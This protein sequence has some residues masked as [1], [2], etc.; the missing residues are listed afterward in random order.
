MAFN[1]ASI[2]KNAV[3]PPII[4]IHGEP[5]VGKTTFGACAPNPIFLQTEDGLGDLNVVAF[6][7]ITELNQVHEALDSLSN[8]Q[9]E[10]QTLVLDSVD[11]M[12]PLIW[13]GVAK[14]N[15]VDH[16]ERLGYGKGYV[17]AL[18]Y[19]RKVLDKIKE[20][21]DQKNMAI[22]MIAHSEKRKVEDPTMP[23]YDSWDLKLHKRAAAMVEEFADIILFACTQA[24]TVTED[25][26]FNQS[27]TRVTTTGNRIMHT[28][29]QPAFLAKNRFSLPTPLP[30]SWESLATALYGQKTAA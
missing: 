2:R 10:F 29:G 22:V 7:F 8:E 21:R 12:E 17:E 16:I 3:K 27:R 28:V 9:H 23:A 13:A 19:W 15:K 26:G 30:L 11:W 18:N 6:P 24:N 5:G 4:V 20:L 1:L 14:D 25:K